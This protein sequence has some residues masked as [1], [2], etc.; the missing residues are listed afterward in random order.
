MIDYTFI[1]PASFRRPAPAD[2]AA[3]PPP[4]PSPAVAALK[5]GWAYVAYYPYSVQA[6]NGAGLKEGVIGL[7]N[8]GRTRTPTEWGVLRA[9][10][11]GASRIADLLQAD[12]AIDGKHLAVAGLSRFGKSTLVAT[13]FDDRFTSALVGSSGA[14]GAKLLRRNYGE[15]VENLEASGEFH[16]SR[17]P[18]C[19]TPGR[20][21]WTTC[22]WMRTC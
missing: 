8:G 20:A 11:W 14:G 10:G 5:R 19:A 1:F 3:P 4:P 7:I 16:C 9:W 22:Q 2:G 13:A 18:S 15:Q 6:D 17:R 21:R 12:P